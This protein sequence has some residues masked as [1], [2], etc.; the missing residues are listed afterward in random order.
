MSDI[1]QTINVSTEWS[2]TMV[3]IG[4]TH[5]VNALVQRVQLAPVAVVRLCGPSSVDFGPFDDYPDDLSAVIGAKC[6]FVNGGYQVD[7]S[8]I[9]EVDEEEIIPV[10]QELKD[11]KIENI[12]IS[13]IFSPVNN[14]Q[15]K[16]VRQ[17][18]M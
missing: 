6:Y 4:T 7:G 13:G 11:R 12:V 8:I 1:N 16:Q 9:T 17:L 18:C 3:N 15:E 14:N 10:I 2:V 5:F